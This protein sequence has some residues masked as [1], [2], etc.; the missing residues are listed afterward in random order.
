MQNDYYKNIEENISRFLNELSEKIEKI[1]EKINV[2]AS[3]EALSA[4]AELLKNI[5]D[6]IKDTQFFENVQKLQKINLHYEDVIWVT[7]EF[8]VNYSKDNWEKLSDGYSTKSPLQQYIARIIVDQTLANREKLIVL[9]A[10]MEPLIYETLEMTKTKNSKI[11]TDVCEVSVKQN[12][13]MTS[14]SFEKVFVLAVVYIVFANTNSY[15]E[16]IDT[17]LP[18]RNNILHNGI[19]MYGNDDIDLAYELLVDLIEILMSLD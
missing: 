8:G 5:P 12:S 6:D 15:T 4:F 3:L 17:R 11:K 14:E 10:H 13:G 16:I 2:S 19:V 7:E 9:L 18:F 1:T